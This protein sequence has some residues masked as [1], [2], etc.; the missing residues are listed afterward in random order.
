MLITCPHS[1]RFFPH[2][3]EDLST[4]LSCLSPSA[5]P[6][7]LASIEWAYR[8]VVLLWLSLII[9]IP[10]GLVRFDDG[11]AFPVQENSGTGELETATATVQKLEN[12][13]KKY[14]QFP[15]MEGIGASCSSRGSTLGTLSPMS[16]VTGR[17]ANSNFT[18]LL[19]PFSRNQTRCRCCRPSSL[20]QLLILRQM[21]TAS[22][23]ASIPDG[24]CILG[25]WNSF[26]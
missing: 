7:V 23:C 8:Y 6:A 12:L 21:P 15:G 16:H 18:A 5:D 11:D 19:C 9:K 10:F 24:G 4:A 20:L 22:Q 17:I 3:V 2:Q 14:L 25:S 1:V 26:F 13:G